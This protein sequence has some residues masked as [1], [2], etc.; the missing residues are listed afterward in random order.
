MR[1]TAATILLLT[2]QCAFAGQLPVL[3]ETAACEAV[4]ARG[5][6]VFHLGHRAHPFC[7]IS[8]DAEPEFFIIGLHAG[9]PCPDHQDSCVGLVGW[10]AVRKGGSQVIRWDVANDRP[11]EPL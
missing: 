4:K 6:T 2:S 11:G 9:L 5:V 7:E 1:I 3:T 8:T 10:Y